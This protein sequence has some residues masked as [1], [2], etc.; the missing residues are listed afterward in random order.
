MIM[1]S[2]VMSRLRAELGLGPDD[3]VPGEL[4]AAVITEGLRAQADQ[5]QDQEL[6]SDDAGV[7]ASG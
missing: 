2:S 6:H 4:I 1:L 7:A 5:E 3:F